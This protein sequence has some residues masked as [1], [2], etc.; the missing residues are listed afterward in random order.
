LYK[1]NEVARFR[2][3]SVRDVPADRSRIVLR[4][5]YKSRAIPFG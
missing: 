4:R 2:P 1:P 5:L 3:L